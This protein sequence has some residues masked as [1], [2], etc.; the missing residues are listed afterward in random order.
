MTDSL[1]QSSVTIDGVTFIA[2]LMPGNRPENTQAWVK[3]SPVFD[4]RTNLEY[5]EPTE[6]NPQHRGKVAAIAGATSDD[7]AD[8]RALKIVHAVSRLL[9][10]EFGEGDAIRAQRHAPDTLMP[11]PFEIEQS[12]TTFVDS[13]SVTGIGALNMLK[14][15]LDD[16]SRHPQLVQQEIEEH[17][18]QN[19]PAARTRKG[20]TPAAAP[21]RVNLTS[22]EQRTGFV[23]DDILDILEEN[24]VPKDTRPKLAGELV[25][26][27]T[28]Q[29]EEKGFAGRVRPEGRSPGS[30]VP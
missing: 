5:H 16:L 17:E 9:T 25:R 22:E 18:A 24:G 23:L 11:T 19:V 28:Q 20:Q 8:E 7:A 13:G 26:Y 3:V 4:P 2:R 10:K 1:N 6:L 14:S 29:S 15:Y 12:S 30:K 21:R 27:M